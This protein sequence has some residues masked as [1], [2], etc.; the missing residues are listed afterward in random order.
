[1]TDFI[2]W[3]GDQ[4]L[5]AL[6]IGGI[7]LFAFSL[8]RF[9]IRDKEGN[10]APAF[11]PWII[12]VLFLLQ[13][14][15][16]FIPL[17][18]GQV[19]STFFHLLA[20][21]VIYTLLLL[22]MTPLLRKW[23]SAEGC[24][25]LWIV[26]NLLFYTFRLKSI[27]FKPL[28]VLRISRRMLWIAAGIWAAGFLIVLAWKLISHFRFRKAVLKD[29][30][31]VTEDERRLFRE[32]RAAL[33][34]TGKDVGRNLPILRSPAVDSP[35]SVGLFLR[36]AQ[37]VLPQREYSDEEL[38]LIFRHEIIHLLHGDNTLK[39]SL[40]FLCAAGWFIPSVWSG[41]GKAAEELELCCDE[42]ATKDM[43]KEERMQYAALLLS[44]AGTAKGFTTCLSTTASGLR[45]RM[46]QVLHP[47]KRR[48]GF[49][50]VALMAVLFGLFFGVVGVTATGWSVEKALLG[51]NGGGW[52]IS[53]VKPLYYDQYGGIPD[54]DV[55]TDPVICGKV[56]DAIRDLELAEPLDHT[57]EIGF[58]MIWFEMT[59]NNETIGGL[60]YNSGLYWDWEDERAGYYSFSDPSQINMEALRDMIPP[61]HTEE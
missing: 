57:E 38:R 15:Y 34:F 24:A 33:C 22:I 44:N 13:A 45:Y 12:P 43:A 28:F 9:I 46:T 50:A 36:S 35:L 52:H 54:P 5:N 16:L 39:F 2:S 42:L 30:L 27:R 19:F 59:R 29:A 11:I 18:R 20:S 3:L 48:T 26:P 10:Y 49:L 1:M 4:L 60:L 58:Q 31:P 23:I 37:L 61:Y 32:V 41:F 40:T 47:K 53:A 17:V 21:T 51:W 8:W 7:C 25:A 56:E 14:L 6:T 55:C